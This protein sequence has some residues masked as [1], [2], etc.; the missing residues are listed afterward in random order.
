MTISS[1]AM[2]HMEPQVIFQNVSDDL[3]VNIYTTYTG[4]LTGTLNN[5][6]TRTGQSC[7]HD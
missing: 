3:A 4:M 6:S 7:K 5:E 1:R 2:G